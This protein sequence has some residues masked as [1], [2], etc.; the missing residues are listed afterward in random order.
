MIGEELPLSAAVETLSIAQ[1]QLVEIAKALVSAPRVLILDE[2]TS[3]LNSHEVDT[4]LALVRRLAEQGVAVIYVSHRMKEIPIVADSMTVL[5]NGK[6]VATLRP[7]EAT[8]DE[9]AAMIAGESADVAEQLSQHRERATGPVVLSVHDLRVADRLF[10][11]SLRLHQGEV[12]GIAGLLGS[13]RTELLECLYG[14]RQPVAGEVQ[15]GGR[16]VKRANPRRM[17]RAKVG[18]TSEDRKGSGIVPLLGVGEN[19]VLAA[20]GRRLPR[21]WISRSREAKLARSEIERLSIAASSAGQPISELSGG[22]QQKVVISRMLAARTQILLLD[23]PTRGIDIHAKGQIY[24]LIRTLAVEGVSTIFVSSELEEMAEVCDRVLV[25]RDGVI[26]D[27]LD[28]TSA[29]TERL[30][31]LA[32]KEGN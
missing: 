30:L 19:I 11:V 15:V 2:P 20:R 4:L 8:A 31:A 18:F 14:V 23:E 3:A 9:V 21:W 27:D 10:G 22:N 29:T 16:V 28:G 32:M 5:R 12:L 6:E 7:D 17:L 1:Q 25:L 26:S 24:T 13:G